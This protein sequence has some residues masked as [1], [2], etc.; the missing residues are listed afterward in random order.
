MTE[1]PED[2]KYTKEHEWVRVSGA[3]GTVGIT[4]Y[5]QAQL[6]DIVY[7]ELPQVGN[8]VEQFGTLG[9]I[10]SVK[11]ASDLFAPVSGTVTGVNEII[12]DH[13]EVINKSPY[14]EG[15]IIRMKLSDPSELDVLMSPSDYK[16]FVQSLGES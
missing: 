1:I 15:W 16:A 5:A 13:P 12:R 3:E 14:D 2:L 11:A 9:V 8:S 7:V 6:G 10:E 4:D